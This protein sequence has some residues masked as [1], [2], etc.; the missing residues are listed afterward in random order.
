M[1]KDDLEKFKRKFDR[2]TV[3]TEFA[4]KDINNWQ[5]NSNYQPTGFEMLDYKE[6]GLQNG[7]LY[8][9]VG[10]P[11]CGKTSFLMQLASNI[12][13]QGR[14]VLMVTP[15][16]SRVTL[17]DID[18]TR[19]NF[20]L[21][22]YKESLAVVINDNTIGIE[23]WTNKYFD[24][25]CQNGMVYMRNIKWIDVRFKDISTDMIQKEVEKMIAKG[26]KPVVIV[27]TIQRLNRDKYSARRIEL[28]DQYERVAV[29]LKAIA[30]QYDLPIVTSS[31]V[32]RDSYDERSEFFTFE[33]C[34]RLDQI[35]DFLLGI[36]NPS[37]MPEFFADLAKK[38]NADLVVLKMVN[39]AHKAVDG[40][41]FDF[42]PKFY[43]FREHEE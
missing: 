16:E 4:V 33:D 25:A 42:Y 6:K 41:V 20:V 18:V 24:Q 43:T 32:D 7:N 13:K 29:D 15:Y 40:F 28:T 8:A 38:P 26:N 35:A 37:L 23:G 30:I 21:S 2:V 5:R 3:I 12:A 27:D 34:G 19:E 14:Q 9:L 17:G 10:K 22:G 36:E 39:K 31:M 1:E 11:G